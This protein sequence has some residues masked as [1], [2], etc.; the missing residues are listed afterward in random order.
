[1]SKKSSWKKIIIVGAVL[2]SAYAALQ[3]AAVRWSEGKDI[4]EEN[5]YRKKETGILPK[6]ENV[7]LDTVKPALDKFLSAG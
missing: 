5:S 1:M 7:Y 4:N 3:T 2:G 6:E